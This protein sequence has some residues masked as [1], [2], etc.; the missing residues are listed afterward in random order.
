MST[1]VV[2]E[3]RK[4]S[5]V[6]TGQHW[7]ILIYKTL[8]IAHAEE[9]HGYPAYTEQ[10]NTVEHL[11]FVSVVEWEQAVK[12]LHESK[13]RPDYVAFEVK[14]LAKVTTTVSTLVE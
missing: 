9:G 11:V 6:P 12:K 13:N 3:A 8:T 14:N 7:A 2:R 1:M 5:D 4:S 10:I